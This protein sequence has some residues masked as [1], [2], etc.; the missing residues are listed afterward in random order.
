MSKV[1]LFSLDRS[2][3]SFVFAFA[4]IRHFFRTEQNAWLH[5]LATMMVIILSVFARVT[6][7]EAVA[8]VLCVALV[9]ITEML[10]TAVEKTMDHLSPAEHPQV[11]IIKD[12]AAGAVL[13]AAIA[14]CIVA[15]IIFI[16]KFL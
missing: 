5:A 6:A 7:M 11:K 3:N 13:T 4:G 10:N 16:P 2:T 14:A 15:F 8:I 9:W 12:V 1:N